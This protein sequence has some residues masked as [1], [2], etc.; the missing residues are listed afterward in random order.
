VSSNT[1]LQAQKYFLFQFLKMQ[2]QD[3]KILRLIKS[4]DLE[5]RKLGE[6]TLLASL[7]I[8]NVLYWYITLDKLKE[9][10]SLNND[11]DVKLT[12]L[13]G[14]KSNKPA[15]ESLAKMVEFIQDHQ[16]S[17]S[18]IQTFFDY[19]N[20]YLFSLMSNKWGTQHRIAIKSQITQLNV[21]TTP[22]KSY[23]DL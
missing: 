8:E 20:E 17:V 16:V 14:W 13:L 10:I 4:E 2:S 7:N 19:Y 1:V 18:S 5:N 3:K 12:A 6:L 9:C 22:T 21:S 23:E 15:I 11:V